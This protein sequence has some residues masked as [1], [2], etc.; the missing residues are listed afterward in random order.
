MV[1]LSLSATAEIPA[2]YYSSLTGK[3]EA[4]LKTAVYTLVKN[5]TSVS[6]YQALPEYFQHT[7][8]YPNSRRWWEM[9]S[10]M[11]FYIPS[12]SGMNR[13]HSFPKSWW[14]GDTE[15]NAYTDLNHLYPSEQ[16]ANQAKSNYPLGEVDRT[17]S[18]KFE[19]GVTTVGYPVNG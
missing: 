1:L 13:E 19:N 11:T 2:G 3:S 9:Y 4:Q 8:V 10:N 14:G 18:I 6:S 17:R 5:F 16:R 7:D 12:F 15:V